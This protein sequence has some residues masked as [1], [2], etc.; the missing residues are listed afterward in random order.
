MSA[1]I[2]FN[3]NKKG[4]ATITATVTFNDGSKKDV[5]TT[6]TV[7]KYTQKVTIKAVKKT[8]KAK[9]LKKKKKS[10]K[11]SASA[12]TA[13]TCKKVSGL[14]GVKVSK[15]GKVTINKGKYAKKTYKVKVKVAAKATAKYDSAAKT[16]TIKITVK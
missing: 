3:A 15:S 9:D 12:E 14:K 13:I 8:Y 4:S 5:S 11:I 16:V 10:F 7:T 2:F 6:I 1:A